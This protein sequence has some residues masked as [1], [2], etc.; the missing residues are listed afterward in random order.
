MHQQTA[1]LTCGDVLLD[2]IVWEPPYPAQGILKFSSGEAL[3]APLCPH[4]DSG[5]P[6]GFRSVRCLL[7]LKLP[8]LGLTPGHCLLISILSSLGHKG[9][10]NGERSRNFGCITAL[11]P[12][13]PVVSSGPTQLTLSLLSATSG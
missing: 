5:P 8:V 7:T 4:P 6:P 10:I 1:E 3:K 2:G 9:R 11:R 13:W 12:S